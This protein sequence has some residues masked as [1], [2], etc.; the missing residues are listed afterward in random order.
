MSSSLICF[1]YFIFFVGFEMTKCSNKIETF[2]D[3]VL[4]YN[5][6]KTSQNEDIHTLRSA[7]PDSDKY[8]MKLNQSTVLVEGEA[9]IGAQ[10]EQHGEDGPDNDNHSV[11]SVIS[12][13]SSSS[14]TFSSSSSSSSSISSYNSFSS[15][16]SSS[17][18]L[19]SMTKKRLAR[20]RPSSHIWESSS[21]SS[22]ESSSSSSSSSRPS[23]KVSRTIRTRKQAHSAQKDTSAATPKAQVK[24]FVY[25]VMDG[26]I[27]RKAGI[28]EGKDDID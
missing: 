15:S 23:P 13:S 27:A 26:S 2:L 8:G 16:S 6:D 22:S 9:S 25:S 7:A 24:T 11:I 4:I 21:S 14:S 17:S 1:L 20:K 12:L 19:S 28:K 10:I 18:S 3:F 5:N